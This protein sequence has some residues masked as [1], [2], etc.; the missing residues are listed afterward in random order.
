MIEKKFLDTTPSI[1]IVE[2]D[3]LR[4]IYHFWRGFVENTVLNQKI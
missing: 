2:L 3:T 4:L 1:S